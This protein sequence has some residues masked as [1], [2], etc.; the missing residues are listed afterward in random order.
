MSIETTP[1]LARMPRRRWAVASLAMLSGLV[2][3][4]PEPSAAQD[5]P[6]AGPFGTNVLIDGHGYG[7]GIGLSQYG[8]YGYA[9]DH[10]K[11]HTWILDHYYGGTLAGT[12]PPGSISVRLTA[13]DGASTAVVAGPSG[14]PL[15]TSAGAGN[16][17]S[18]VAIPTGA[19]SYA[20]WGHGSSRECA[21]SDPAA[22]AAAGWVQV[23][24]ASAG[25]IEL[26][27]AAGDTTTSALADLIGVCEANGAVRSHRGYIFAANDSAGSR[28]TVNVQLVESY[29]RSVVGAEVPW[30]WGNGGGGAG[31]NALRAQAVAARSY[32]LAQNRYSYVASPGT[33]LTLSPSTCDTQ[34]CQV[35]RGAALRASPAAGFT[36]DA[37]YEFALTDLAVGQ[38]SGQ[39]RR[40][41]NGNIVSTMFSSSSGGWTSGG[42]GFTPVEDLG[43]ATASNKRHNWTLSIPVATIEAKWP[44]IGTLQAIT[45]AGRNGLGDFG[46]RITPELG[47]VVVIAGTAGSV[48]LTGDEVR[49]ALGLYSNWFQVRTACAGRDEPPVTTGSITT[50]SSGFTPISAQ[51]AIDTRTG[52]GTTVGPILR[53]CTLAVAFPAKPA[54]TT[55]VA[56]NITTTNSMA[57]GFITAYPCGTP[58]PLA[59][60]VQTQVNADI[61]VMSVVPLG[62]DGRICL[63][64]SVPTDLVV[65]VMGWFTSSGGAKFVPESPSRL[66]DSRLRGPLPGP[67]TVI[68]VQVTGRAGKPMNATAASVNVVGTEAR[69]GTYVTAYPCG[70]RA[71]T[72]VVNIRP[73]VDIGNHAL[74]PLDASGGFC[75]WASNDVHLV[76][77]IDG[78][79]APT[80]QTFQFAQPSRAVDT[81]QPSANGGRFARNETR[82]LDLG[83]ASGSAAFVLTVVDP[84]APGH[85]TVWKPDVS[86]PSPCGVV[87]TTAV[88]NTPA[89]TNLAAFVMVPTDS[90]GR[91][92]VNTFMPTDLVI[93]MSGRSN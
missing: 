61:P 13:L 72:S 33:V 26:F 59:A 48:A 32:A 49:Q 7:H 54:G 36:P 17:Q 60:G 9:V 88:I 4:A 57:Q 93:D 55:A 91:I 43:D 51:R 78:V 23:S 25:P 53:G 68:R 46:G 47:K 27:P 18:L 84:G 37:T 5:V 81:R 2:V 1:P 79:F 31:M 20:V 52:T 38:T 24:A 83:P 64:A 90:Q 89:R 56:V 22:L 65:D 21:S 50:P 71:L 11:D 82:L 69:A 14:G 85:V 74:V 19:N 80:G 41:P 6:T 58:R 30:S 63:F 8:A 67:N 45:V 62:P 66:L 16:Y 3:A 86:K 40:W 10:G 70:P 44:A 76:V 35:Y 39:V 92:C 34:A 73:G 12:A 29:L 87:P 42:A 75:L 77:D 28:R 15:Q